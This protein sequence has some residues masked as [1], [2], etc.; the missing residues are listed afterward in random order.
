VKGNAATPTGDRPT[1][2]VVTAWVA[3]LM[4]DTALAVSLAT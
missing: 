4:T 2:T 3:A 1:G